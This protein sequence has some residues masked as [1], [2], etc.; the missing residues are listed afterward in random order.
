MPLR[1]NR[2]LAWI[3]LAVCVTGSVFGLGGMHLHRQ[4]NAV[5]DVFYS[6]SVNQRSM[7]EL[8][9]TA[10]AC[11]QIMAGEV[12]IY[13][14]GT[15]TAAALAE[16]SPAEGSLDERCAAYL[17]IREQTDA[18]YNAMYAKE[19]LDGERVKFKRAY[20]EFWRC[21][22]Q[23][24]RHPY[25]EMAAEYNRSIAAFPACIVAAAVNAGELNC[26]AL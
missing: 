23:I 24:R 20:D 6:G 18:M 4:R 16:T 8:L 3:V 11:A 5:L 14:T 12:Q 21:D 26:F 19:M 17:R 15:D 1:R 7:D 25:C 9:D 10:A 2:T 22:A 13:L